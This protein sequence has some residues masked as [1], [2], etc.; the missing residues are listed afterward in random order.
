MTHK[1]FYVLEIILGTLV[2]NNYVSLKKYYDAV[3]DFGK[4]L[5]YRYVTLF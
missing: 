5:M 1:F 2:E 3:H 4:M